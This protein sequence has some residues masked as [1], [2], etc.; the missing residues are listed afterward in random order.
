MQNK[1]DT[2]LAI[3][4]LFLITTALSASMPR[5]G[6]RRFP[7]RCIGFWHMPFRSLSD[8]SY[9]SQCWRTALLKISGSSWHIP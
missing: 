8:R 5:T 2:R 7:S 6:Q 9:C 4:S 3:G 1:N